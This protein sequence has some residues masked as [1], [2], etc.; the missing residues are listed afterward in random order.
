VKVAGWILS[1]LLLGALAAFAMQ[2]LR[3]RPRSAR[4]SGYLPPRPAV[5]NRVVLPR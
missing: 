3:P 2:L 5:D 1:G 4:R